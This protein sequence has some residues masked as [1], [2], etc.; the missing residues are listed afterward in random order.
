MDSQGRIAFDVD[1]QTDLENP[2]DPTAEDPFI[3]VRDYTP[4]GSERAEADVATTP[5]EPVAPARPPEPQAVA[6]PAVADD[7]GVAAE[8]DQ[9]RAHDAGSG[10]DHRGPVGL[11]PD[12][13][14]DVFTA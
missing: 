7:E 1:G 12:D 6:E 2:A 4:T 3:F 8:L 9:D 13:L 10:E 5:I 14:P 11:Q